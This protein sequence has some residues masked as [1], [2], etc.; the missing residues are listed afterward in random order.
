MTDIPPQ[1][2]AEVVVTAARLGPSA[3]DAAF[4]TRVLGSGE[5]RHHSRV[6]QA[7]SAI[8]AVTLF[9]RA[10]SAAA[11]PTTQG[12]SLRA[13]APS[14]AGRALVTLDGV[15]LN[16]PFGG[17]VIWA[18]AVPESL[19]D[20]EIIRG[21]GSGPYGAGALTGTVRM[22]ET[23]TDGG[24]ADFSAGSRGSLRVA[25]SGRQ[26]IGRSAVSISASHEHS[27]GYRPVRGSRAGRADVPMDLTAEALSARLDHALDDRVRLSLRAAS[28]EE[29]RGSGQGDNR[30]NA[31]GRNISATLAKAPAPGQAGWR[32]QLWETRSNLANS[33][34]SISPDR[35]TTTPANEQYST[36]A[37]GRGL[38]L[39]LRRSLPVAG[40]QLEWE[41]GADAR[42][43]RGATNELFRFMDG[44]FTRERQA[45][46]EASVAGAYI[47][48]SWQGGPWQAAA[49]LRVDH[50]RNHGGFRIERDRQDGTPLL[51]ESEQ[52][53]DGTLASYRLGLRRALADGWSVR[54]AA[55]SAFRPASLN[56]LHRPFRVGNDLT[57]ANAS[58]K[59]ETLNGLEAGLTFEKAALTFD[60]TGFTNRIEDAVV[61]VT[62]AEGPGTFPRAG[63]VPAGGVLRQRMNAGTVEATGIEAEGRVRLGE[64]LEL[65]AAVSWTDARMKGGQTAPQLD[66]LRP[67][68]APEWSGRVGLEWYATPDL[69]LRTTARYESAR[70]DDDLNLRTLAAAWTVDARV[71]WQVL[72][73]ATLW[74][75]GENLLDEDM[76]TSMTS[77]GVAGYTAPRTVRAGIRLTY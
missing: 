59:P 40:G 20:V 42:Q 1:P 54:G 36:P 38:N 62:L 73:A 72:P 19:S 58:L 8:P 56:E 18:Q 60:V 29:D 51:D 35:N 14:G 4:S 71:E 64:S 25:A 53:A 52:S 32:V 44:T 2:V 63:F 37:R 16:D 13:I 47:D 22:A 50:W 77:T 39:A 10:D 11:N 26:T 67:A 28:W 17:W 7:L 27:D 5:L 23:D 6:D 34:S 55:Y 57:E 31:S 69:S 46:G 41:L 65:G 70:F 9:R 68:Q 12:L 49:G 45:G 43:M 15:P 21:A 75:S 66:G 33:S 74:L 3:A 76:E 48:G 24:R 61:N 30:A